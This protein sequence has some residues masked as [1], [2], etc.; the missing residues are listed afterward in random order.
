M[1]NLILSVA[2]GGKTTHIMNLI[3]KFS[4]SGHKKLT[5]IVPEQF[6]FTSEKI[7]LEKLGAKAMAY[8]DVESFTSLGEKL[9]GR[10]ALH[11][12]KR[13]SEAAKAVLMK[14]ALESVQ[15]KLLLYGKHIKRQS[16]ISEFVALSTEFKRNTLST[17]AVRLA[18]SQRENSLLK[19]KLDDITTVL[20][21]YDTLVESSYFNPDDLL[22]ELCEILPETD[23]FDGRLVFID[24]F[25]GF[26]SQEYKVLAQMLR[27]SD[28]IYITLCTDNLENSDDETDLFAHTKRSSK[29]LIDL[30]KKEGAGVAKPL[31]LSDEKH[32]RFNSPE[33]SALE[34]ELFSPVPEIYEGNCE[35]IT[36]CK[37]S[38]IYSECEYIA[39]TAKKLIRE[40]GMR[41]RDIAVI[42]RD[43]TGYEAPLKS[44]LKKCGIP[45]FEDSRQPVEA[46]PVVA[47]ISSAIASCADGFDTEILMRY[48]K[49][50]ISGFT[51]EEISEVENYTYLWKISGE[52]WNREWT[53]SPRGFGEEMTEEDQAVLDNI[54]D[55]RKK[56][57]TP[58]Y[59]LRQNLQNAKIGEATEFIFDFL[60]KQNTAENIRSLA[61][62]LENQG[63]AGLA[64]E[65]ERMWNTVIDILDS[66]YILSKHKAYSPREISEILDLMLSVQTVGSLPQGLDEITIGSADRSRTASPKVVFIAGA[67]NGVFPAL[68]FTGSALTDTDRR[69]MSEMGIEL[70]DYGE[71]KLAEEKLIAYTAFCS[72]SEMLFV[73]CPEKTA[74]GEQLA[75]SELYTKI[76][77]IF[78]DCKEVRAE[79]LDGLY[80]IEGEPLAFEQLA[81]NKHDDNA[82]YATLSEYFEGNSDYE[83]R[84]SALER[85][86]GN[87]EF[88]IKDSEISQSLFGKDMYISASRVESFYKCPFSYFCRYGIKAMPRAVAELDPMQRGTVIHY[89]LEMLLTT[90][91]RSQ[92]SIMSRKELMEF[93]EKL[94]NDYLMSRLD[95]ANRNERFLYLFKKLISSVCDVAQRLIAE[96][97]QSKFSPVDFELKIGNG[98]E[99]PAYTV[100]T[101]IGSVIISGSIDRVDEAVLGGKKYIRVVDY[102]SSGKDFMLSDVVQGLNMQMFIYLFA[103]WQNGGKKYGE[104]T[105]AGVLYCPANSPVIS[106]GRNADEETLQKEIQKRCAMNGIV[107]NDPQV[108]AAMDENQNGLY[109]PAKMKKDGLSGS[110]INLSQLEKLKEKADSILVDMADALHS[111]NIPACP[112]YG[113]SYKS[114]CEYCDYKSV[115]SYEENIPVN[116]L[117][118]TDL[119]TVLKDLEKGD[120][121]NEMDC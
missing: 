8:V 60:K 13:L 51:T 82:L 50:G 24:S 23:Y 57:V 18:M 2:G 97:S 19:M 3:E 54:N 72:A 62:S 45:V 70:S 69:R 58:L 15:D 116:E 115:C 7:M 22:T 47:F 40:K 68:P 55:I 110:L 16:V 26:T 39:V 91:D 25:R 38:D 114:T 111:G 4:S 96:L 102:K 117:Y 101:D 99:I 56:I 37:A 20:D 31:Y 93:F 88:K 53:Q 10:P 17:E 107:L 120:D 34:N 79:S 27:K 89:A 74:K 61:L 49:T 71:Y 76:K 85:A 33:L 29:K 105:P 86:S 78:T 81:S 14:T 94:L 104:F 42:A 77:N 21:T 103:L 75:P 119:Q 11:E 36:L 87:R 41:Y 113:K 121:K 67:N 83:G 100:E 112:S 66:L 63:E 98:G 108:V 106:A 52:S 28:D 44:A 43:S 59:F 80:Y 5:L 73:C 30:A 1:L 65:L 109:I 12:R 46:S 84:I 32:S 92:L 90:Y 48:L 9:V 95:G 35:N 118:D 6:S 64:L